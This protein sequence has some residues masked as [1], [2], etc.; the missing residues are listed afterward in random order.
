MG[1]QFI[2]IEAYARVGSTQTTTD[3]TGAKIFKSKRSAGDIAAEA[4]RNEAHSKHVSE[5]QQPKLLWGVSP[6][7]AV[8]EATA[9]ADG[10]KDAQGRKLRK[11]ALCLLAGV[12]SVSARDKDTWEEHKNRSV[13]W[14]RAKYGGRLKS[15]VE[16]TDEA[17]PHLHFYCVPKPGE[18]FEAVHDGYKASAEA[19]K[20]GELKGAQNTAYKQ[21]MKALQ[22]QFSTDVAIKVGLTRIGPKRRRLTREDWKLEQKQAK[23]I[24]YAKSRAK[25]IEG[26]AYTDAYTKAT[27]EAAKKGLGIG[28]TLGGVFDGLKM[29][30]HKPSNK[31]Q[32]DLDQALKEKKE[33]ELKNRELVDR[34][35]HLQTLVKPEPINID[36]SKSA[37]TGPKP[38][39]E[40][41]PEAKLNLAPKHEAKLTFEP[42]PEAK[43][44]ASEKG[45][46]P[47]P[48]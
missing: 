16:H 42:K 24:L 45:Y 41:I 4:E 5:P 38:T 23:A 47:R 21:A 43:T 3:K 10:A 35:K 29:S 26:K 11:D 15:V 22:D 30:W 17:N 31:A 7:Q 9:W 14:L 19:K 12:V 39:L 8:A 33:L 2:H 48:R 13:N 18:R 20:A 6:S 25:K 34:V 27:A 1:Y 44:K 32:D 37:Y 40:P 46:R 28:S 36:A